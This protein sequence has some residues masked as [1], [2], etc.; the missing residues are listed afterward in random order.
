MAEINLRLMFAQIFRFCLWILL[1]VLEG[2]RSDVQNDLALT[3]IAFQK[4]QL[5]NS[6]SEIYYIL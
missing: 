2:V 3:N 4:T 1:G 5:M 6:I